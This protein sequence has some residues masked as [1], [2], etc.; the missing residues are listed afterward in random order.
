VSG[1]ILEDY[2]FLEMD[3]RYA[4]LLYAAKL[5]DLSPV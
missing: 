2:P 5:T 1:L 4:C 3:D